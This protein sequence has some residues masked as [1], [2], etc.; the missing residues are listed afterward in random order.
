MYRIII[1]II[2]PIDYPKR[3]NSTANREEKET[4]RNAIRDVNS[5]IPVE[6]TN[7]N[8]EKPKN[9]VN[10]SDEDIAQEKC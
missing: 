6:R 5:T 2:Q 1:K 8:A 7:N 3:K 10:K 4:I 9:I